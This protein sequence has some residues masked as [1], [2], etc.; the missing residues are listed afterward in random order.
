[1][2]LHD[3]AQKRDRWARLRFAIIGPLLAAP[4]TSRGELRQT[5]K[6]L[7]KKNWTHPVTGVTIRFGFSTLE[8]WYYAARKAQDPVAVL[9]RRKRCDSGRSRRLPTC[10]V[11]VIKAQYQAHPSWTVQLHYDNL[12][13]Q[14][15]EDEALGRLP[16]YGTI[17]RYMKA[18]GYHRRRL[19]KTQTAAA[20]RAAYRLERHE[21][22]S[23]EAEHTLALWHL[24]F[25]HGSHKVLTR[26]GQWMTPLLL[27]VIDD[28]SRLICHLQWYLDETAESLVHGLCQGFQKRGLPRA[29]MTDNGAAMQADEFCQGLQSLSILHETT[30]PYSPYQNAKQECFWATLEGRLMAMLESVADL[31]LERLNK[32]TQAWVEQEYHR[33]QHAEIGTCPLNR[34]LDSPNV[35]RDCPDSKTLRRAFRSMGTRRQRRSDGTLSLAGIRFEVPAR[36]RHLETLQ[37]S[38]ARWDLSAVELVDPHDLTALCALYPLDKTANAEGQRRRLDSMETTPTAIPQ[39]TGTEL[40]PLLH[41]LVAEYAATGRPP[42][43]LPQHDHDPEV[44]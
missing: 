20:N 14:V 10:L 22:R 8:R 21:V 38:Y 2:S 23:F 17:R 28:H 27:G 19:P 34:Y 5:L 30:L 24:D 37:I 12:A 41:K 44:A 16:S 9:R 36:Y 1:M 11:P 40:P 25:H 7:A 29:L 15:T 32:I 4:P 31:T 26:S 39:K 35:G 42:A 18:Q 43:Y 33:T 3:E 6:G 13:V